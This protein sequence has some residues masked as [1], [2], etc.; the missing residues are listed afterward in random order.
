MNLAI[1]HPR[2]VQS[3]TIYQVTDRSHDGRTARVPGDEI[4]S[5]VSGWL[6]ELGTQSPL[7]DELAR[8]VRIGDWPAAYAIGEHLS[9]RLPLRSKH[10]LT[11][12]SRR[13]DCRSGG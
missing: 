10:H 3:A 5:T 9:L 8:A 1:W 7:A 11:V 4:T 12:S 13:D 6:S 2:K